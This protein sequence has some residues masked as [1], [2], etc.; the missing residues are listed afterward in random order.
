M[1]P[2]T[3]PVALADQYQAAE[4]DL[5]L[6]MTHAAETERIHVSVRDASTWLTERRAR[7][8]ADVT[9]CPH[10]ALGPRPMFTA[11]WTPGIVVCQACLEALDQD[12]DATCDRCGSAPEEFVMNAVRT[13]PLLMFYAL[14]DP[15]AELDSPET[16]HAD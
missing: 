9:E 14:C 6:T 2:I 11:L 7:H 4:R 5:A 1:T 12:E 16:E 13:G 3:N 8:L 10:L 15:C